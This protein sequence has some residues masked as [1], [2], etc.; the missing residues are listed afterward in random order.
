MADGSDLVAALRRTWDALS[1]PAVSSSS[2]G[3]TA[4]DVREFVRGYVEGEMAFTE[5]V[6]TAWHPLADEEK[7]RLLAEAFPD[8][9]SYGQGQAP[10][11]VGD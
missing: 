3:L 8:G 7:E 5:T 1:K 6:A 9:E 2:K 10:P 11:E 4:Q